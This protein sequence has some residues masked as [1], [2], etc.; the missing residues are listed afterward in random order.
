LGKKGG[1]TALKRKP[2]PKIWP[3]HRKE[4]VWV[5]K[6]TPGP[7]SLEKCL[8]LT[9]VLR[10]ILGFAK[11]RKEAKIIVSQGK[12][13]VD[14]RVR[15]EDKFPV[16]LMDVI[17][18]P[19]IDK[20]FRVLP[21]HKGLILHPISKEETTFKLC[22]IENKT[23]VKNGHIQLNLH[24]GSNVLIKVADPKNPQEDV[25]KTFDIVQLS[26]PDRQVIGHIRMKEKDF[27][28]ITGGKN[29]GKYG[30]IVEIEDVKGRKRREAIVTIEDEKGNRYQTIL[31]FVFVVGD[32]KPLI[33]L[34]EI[35]E[36]A[37]NV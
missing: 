32:E 27:A 9:I 3:I 13:Y 37:Q 36:A 29:M 4:Y 14:G 34:P 28:I 22:R 12:V 26:L 33:S 17:S 16:G 30:R 18:F 20:H 21:S 2:A 31:D 7:H 19:E 11:T 5:V 6:P 1:S 15:R 8:P 35:S 24:D 10:E 25:Y 23:T